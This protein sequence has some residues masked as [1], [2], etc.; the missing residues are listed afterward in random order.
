MRLR[1]LFRGRPRLRPALVSA[2]VLAALAG[3][4]PPAAA[5]TYRWDDG[6]AATNRNW[7]NPANWFNI[8]DGTND[9]VPPS[10][11]DVQFGIG[12]AAPIVVNLNGSRTVNSLAFGVPAST[13]LS[14]NTLTVDSGRITV[15]ANQFSGT[16]STLPPTGSVVTAPAII[17][18][19]LFFGASSGV[20]NIGGNAELQ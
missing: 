19:N 2:L 1:R 10:A 14:G 6:G 3:S 4:P 7:D 16:S 9:G 17:N 5:Q 20:I 13:T 11:A 18:S 15:Y 12:Y 8:T